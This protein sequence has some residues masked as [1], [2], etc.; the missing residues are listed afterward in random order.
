MF[1]MEKVKKI[2]STGTKTKVSFN[3]DNHRQ[4]APPIEAKQ[5]NAQQNKVINNDII[6]TR[7]R[8]KNREK[9]TSNIN[10]IHTFQLNI[11]CGKRE[12]E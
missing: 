2:H 11:Q 12:D 5:R 3:T 9:G 1:L 6:I 4:K 7:S 10:K 8:M